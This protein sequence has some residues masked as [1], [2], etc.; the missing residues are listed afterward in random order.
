M[1]APDA[2]RATA[3]RVGGGVADEG[4]DEAVGPDP[5]DLLAPVLPRSAS[6]ALPRP[7]SLSPIHPSTAHPLTKP[8]SLG[9][10]GTVAVQHRPQRRLSPAADV[11]PTVSDA[12]PTVS[13]HLL[14][15]VADTSVPHLPLKLPAPLLFVEPTLLRAREWAGG[16][17]ERARDSEKEEDRRERARKGGRKGGVGGGGYDFAW[18]TWTLWTS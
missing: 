9:R 8:F 12:S 17:E 3:H 7:A 5:Q 6:P 4:A 18:N 16:G 15:T 1:R 11:S 13:A 2:R 14:G 10:S